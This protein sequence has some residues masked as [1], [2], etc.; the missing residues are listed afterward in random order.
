MAWG[1]AFIIGAVIGA[2]NG[3][4]TERI[5]V[6]PSI[7]SGVAAAVSLILGMIAMLVV[8]SSK[9]GGLG[10]GYLGIGLDN[11]VWLLAFLGAVLALHVI[12]G[13]FPEPLRSHRPV[14]LGALGGVYGA[15]SVAW[16][17]AVSARL[18]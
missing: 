14:V 17:M 3:I 18:K 8:W 7:A 12:L 4:V 9:P 2:A 15:L 16:L 6:H 5:D 10:S 13:F 1:I 11:V